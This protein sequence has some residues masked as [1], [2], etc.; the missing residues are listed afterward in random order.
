MSTDKVQQFVFAIQFV[1]M[2]N[3]YFIQLI[4]GMSLTYTCFEIN[5][6]IE[7]NVGTCLMQLYV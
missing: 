3:S 1:M 2:L 4:Y 7:M 6:L 5:N